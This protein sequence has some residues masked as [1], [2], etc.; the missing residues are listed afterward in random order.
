MALISMSKV[1]EI[2]NKNSETHIIN[3]GKISKK[4]E[5]VNIPIKVKTFEETLKLKNDFKLKR[6]KLSIQWQP[7]TR[8]PKAM[9]E[10]IMQDGNYRKG[11]TENTYY[12]TIK[13]S[14]DMDKVER[15]KYRERLFNVLIHLDMEYKTEEN[16]TMWEDAGLS[17][18][19]YDGLVDLFSGIIEYEAHIDMLELIID[20][21][22][23]GA[24][25]DKDL[26][27]VIS[28]YAIRKYVDGLDEDERKEFFNN[29]SKVKDIA[30][31]IENKSSV[32]NKEE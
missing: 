31:E 10:I 19:D 22:R 6:D 8:L 16:K 1:K 27:Q 9:K 32:E 11:A 30:E 13:L 23:N 15:I 29:L 28:M 5:G 25:E 20:S 3:L 14:E 18:D 2:A 26:D 4:L 12:Q 24:Y 7:F 17:K 21:I